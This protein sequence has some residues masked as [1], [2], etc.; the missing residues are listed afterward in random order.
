MIKFCKNKKESGFTLIET[1]I[2][3]S[4]FSISIVTLMTVLSSGISDINYAKKKIT[5]TYL[6]QEG[7]EYARNQRDNYFLSSTTEWND[8]AIANNSVITPPSPDSDFSGFGRTVS[9]VEINPNEV[10][11]TS[12]VTWQQGSGPKK[13][14]FSENLF[15][16]LNQ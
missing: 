6:A 4:I 1:L 11:I 15:N 3:I 9:K 8:F 10:K 14:E 5:A 2:A 13:V 16:W 12:T 7:I